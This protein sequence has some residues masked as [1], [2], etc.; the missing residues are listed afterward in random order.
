MS[1]RV[2]SCL[3]VSFK[4]NISGCS[5]PGPSSPGVRKTLTAAA[6]MMV[7]MISYT[8]CRDILALLDTNITSVRNISMYPKLDTRISVLCLFV[9][10]SRSGDPPLDSETG[11]TEELWSKT[12][13]LNW[14]TKRITFF[15]LQKNISQIF[16]FRKKV[17]FTKF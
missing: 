5:R 14:K 12:N 4:C 9:R 7:N 8:H 1:C 16:W 17:F 3:T 10:P 2:M 6:E 13:L 11:W 15:F